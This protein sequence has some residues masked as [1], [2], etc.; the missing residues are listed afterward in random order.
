MQHIANRAGQLGAI[1][2]AFGFL[3]QHTGQQPAD[4]DRD[5]HR[6]H[7][8]EEFG[9]VP[10]RGFRNNE[11]LRLAD[12][13]HHPAECRAD[14]GVHHQAAQERTKLFQNVALRHVNLAVILQIALGFR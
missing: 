1:A 3:E 4:K 14:A 13:R 12:H 9:K 2:E 8:Q 10:A 6:R 7:A 11:V 5:A